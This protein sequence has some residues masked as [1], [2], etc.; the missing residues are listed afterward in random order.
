LLATA[1][2]AATTPPKVTPLE[3]TRLTAEPTATLV[4]AAGDSLITL[5]EATVVLE[6]MLTIPTVKPAP[7]NAVEAADWVSPT[8]VGAATI[9]SPVEMT[10]ATAEPLAAL[11]PAAGVSLMTLPLATVALDAWVTVPTLSPAPVTAVVAADCVSPTT[12]GTLT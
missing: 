5:P 9:G 11:V 1:L 3:T 2:P 4:P 10:R 12:F 6:A 7:V 8:T